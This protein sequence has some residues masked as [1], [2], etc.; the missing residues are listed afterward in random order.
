VTRSAA[1]HLLFMPEIFRSLKPLSA[2]K[3]QPF[4]R[5]L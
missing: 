1:D 3:D 5:D 4:G 2:S